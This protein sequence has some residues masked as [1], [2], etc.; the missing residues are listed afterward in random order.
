MTTAFAAELCWSWAL[1]AAMQTGPV[2]NKRA[3]PSKLLGTSLWES[4]GERGRG[5]LGCV[6]LGCSGLLDGL[7]SGEWGGLGNRNTH[8]HTHGGDC[9]QMAEGPRNGQKRWRRRRRPATASETRSWPVSGQGWSRN[10]KA[11]NVKSS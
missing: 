4:G 5:R 10:G 2:P 1:V 8:T 9:S 6:W 3:M 11:A 7:E